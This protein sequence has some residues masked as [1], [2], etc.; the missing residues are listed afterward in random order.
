MTKVV[1]P[2]MLEKKKGIIVN[3]SSCVS[4]IMPPMLTG[5][6]ATKVTKLKIHLKIALLI[7]NNY[8]VMCKPVIN[9]WILSESL[10]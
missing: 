2:G 8:Y 5:Y 9:V 4:G 10:I 1:L 7:S 3:L 6:A